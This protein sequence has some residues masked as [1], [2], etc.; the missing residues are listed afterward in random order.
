MA[1]VLV[2]VDGR[3]PADTTLEDFANNAFRAWRIGQ[4]GK[5]NGVLFVAFLDDR[6]M[7]IEVGYGL[8]GAIPDVRARQIT[9]D[10]V[11]PLFRAGDY[12]GG[13]EAA[14]EQLIKLAR[15]EPYRGSGR[16][17]AEGP[18][19]APPA[20]LPVTAFHVAAVLG[21]VVGTAGILAHRERGWPGKLLNGALVASIPAGGFLLLAHLVT[22]KASHFAAAVLLLGFA[23]LVTVSR[24]KIDDE[25]DAI[26]RAA[27]RMCWLSAAAVLVWGMGPAP[28]HPWLLL[29]FVEVAL[30][31]WTITGARAAQTTRDR[32]GALLIGPGLMAMAASGTAMGVGFASGR[33]PILELL[34]FAGSCAF[35]LIA[36]VATK[37][38]LSGGGWSS[39]DSSSS[40][41]WSSSSSDSSWSSSSSSDS[42]S[43]FSG[44][45]GDSGGGGSSDS[46]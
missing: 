21:L 23:G 42:S 37:M 1:V 13:V 10:F 12:A 19:P 20:E 24:T 38:R 17:V 45:G 11:K 35:T 3:L 5:D 43:S 9:N 7:R 36:T 33:G 39:S 16:T 2:Y 29:L 28:G 27:A 6:V 14:A 25:Q 34:A 40:S 22:G 31:L 44:G 41:S 46:W 15:G 26:L 8:E 4:K 30:L 32:V 18:P